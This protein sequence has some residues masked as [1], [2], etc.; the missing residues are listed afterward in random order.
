MEM[1]E[2]TTE[3]MIVVEMIEGRKIADLKEEMKVVRI[4]VPGD[5]AVEELEAETGKREDG[6][7]EV[8]EEVAAAEMNGGIDGMSL[9]EEM[10]TEVDGEEERIVVRRPDVVM[11]MV[12][13][14]G[15]VEET[16]KNE[17]EV[18]DVM[19]GTAG[20][21]EEEMTVVAVAAVAD[22]E[23]QDEMNAQEE[24]EMIDGEE[25]AMTEVLEMTEVPEKIVG[26][27]R[28]VVLAMIVDQGEEM[29]EEVVHGDE[30]EMLQEMMEEHGEEEVVSFIPD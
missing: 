29:I 22:G 8:V 2:E 9:Q 19:V 6:E 30:V 4:V 13:E 24:A 25:D 14:A 23:A 28:T 17:E 12:V 20:V 11:K 5:V 26:Q 7:E 1:I 15:D 27:E 18:V 3:E 10:M 16:E 21:V